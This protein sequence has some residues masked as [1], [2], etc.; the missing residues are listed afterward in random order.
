MARN[1][2]AGGKKIDT[3]ANTKHHGSKGI[4]KAPIAVNTQTATANSKSKIHKKKTAP[5]E[6]GVKEKKFRWRP[7]TVALREIK[8]YQKSVEMVLPRAPF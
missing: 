8:K 7:G 2:I 4:K 3:A 1:K 5:A 6:G